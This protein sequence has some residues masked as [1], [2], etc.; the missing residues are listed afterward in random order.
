[1]KVRI[2]FQSDKSGRTETFDEDQLDVLVAKV[3][4]L[5][6]EWVE[7][8]GTTYRVMEIKE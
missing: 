4:E 5:T 3:I 1:M 6:L 8:E 2:T 7:N